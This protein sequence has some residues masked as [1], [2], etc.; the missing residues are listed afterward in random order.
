MTPPPL[1]FYGTLRDPDIL[2]AAL[3]RFPAPIDL[4]P[5]TAPNHATVYFPGEVY[6]ALVARPGT[7]APGL[8]LFNATDNDRA[9][10]DAYEGDEYHRARLVVTTATA[11]IEAEVYFPVE[12]IPDTA[13]QWTLEQWSILHKPEVLDRETGIARAF[14]RPAT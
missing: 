7:D 9:A 5:A 11:A 14:H 13:I 1:F 2:A 3:G 6:P 8:L 10:L 12:A 4:I